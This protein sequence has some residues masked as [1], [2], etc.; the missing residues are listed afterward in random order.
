[1]LAQDPS[2]TESEPTLTERAK[3]LYEDKADRE[4]FE[5]FL[6]EIE[7]RGD[8][9]DKD[10]RGASFWIYRGLGRLEEPWEKRRKYFGRAHALRESVP[11]PSR[12]WVDESYARALQV[13]QQWSEAREVLETLVEEAESDDWS[14]IPNVYLSL[15]HVARVQRDFD[16]SHAYLD[17]AEDRVQ[18]DGGSLDLTADI[19]R[20]RCNTYIDQGLPSLAAEVW[21]ELWETLI[22]LEKRHEA[23][24]DP[25][26]RDDELARVVLDMARAKSRLVEIRLSV[27]DYVRAAKTARETIDWLEGRQPREAAALR[28]LLGVAL[29]RLEEA[30]P[31]REKEA[32]AV[33]RQ[34]VD[35]D[36]AAL[37]NRIEARLQLARIAMGDGDLDT[38]RSEL[39]RFTEEHDVSQLTIG[40][41][42]MALAF[43]LDWQV[44]AAEASSEDGTIL[45]ETRAQL[46]EARAAGE[47]SMSEVF[48]SWLA[49]EV[50]PTGTGF[51]RSSRARRLMSAL[52]NASLLL[53]E[54]E[55]G[56]AR[57]LSYAIQATRAG[58]LARELEAAPLDPR[59]LHERLLGEGEGLLVYLPTPVAW[60]VFAVDHDGIE[61]ANLPPQYDIDALRDRLLAELLRS[62]YS[63]P[64]AD[65]EHRRTILESGTRE[66]FEML[67]PTSL[68]ERFHGWRGVA[69]VGSDMMGYIPFECLV[70]DRGDVLGLTREVRYLPSLPVA[71]ALSERRAQ[72]RAASTPF[73]LAGVFV[74]SP[75]PGSAVH[76]LAPGLEPLPLTRREAK[77]LV[78]ASSARPWE[79]LLAEHANLDQL[80]TDRLSRSAMIQWLAHGVHDADKD[81]SA[82]IVMSPGAADDGLVDARE[83]ARLALPPV[84]IMTVCGVG[85]GAQRWGDPGTTDLSGAA[86]RSP[87]V[88]AVV[89]PYARVEYGS[90]QRL[91]RELHARLAKGIPLGAAMLEARRELATMENG[92]YSDPFYHSL[93]HVHGLAEVAP[94]VAAV[95]R[96]GSG[97]RG[98]GM[99]VVAA[100]LIV[101]AGL[102]VW[103]ARARS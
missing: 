71:G 84:V 21:E 94:S 9:Q 32:A 31:D 28:T 92:R 22:R 53:E 80:T 49:Q 67:V 41:R 4:A 39:D 20:Y 55:A 61:H 82:R 37:G 3:K 68:R 11:V 63:L 52:V 85:R 36:R 87:R 78:R 47:A 18:R 23:I 57:G 51:L 16:A 100:L 19:L 93:L 45:D 15:G 91:S 14:R 99:L 33:L 42:A 74:G 75:R 34:V 35:D 65:R 29:I 1:M 5:S 59:K 96:R 27:G 95:E 90:M 88:E 24:E 83:L 69:I 17:E 89:L 13:L 48:E 76:D 102:I 40:Q 77:D 73:E 25:D 97:M 60:H 44:A 12:R 70:D 58:A 26:E 50:T 2:A 64:E 10:V 38:A 62:P 101:I 98:V 6:A 72:R 46:E 7:A 54:G 30:D 56:R 66:L 81:V 86:L 103:S 79:I 8:E 43:E